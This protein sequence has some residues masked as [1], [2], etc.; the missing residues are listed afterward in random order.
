MHLWIVP[1]HPIISPLSMDFLFARH[2]H[3]FVAQ[4]LR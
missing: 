1:K 4:A 3:Q 2:L